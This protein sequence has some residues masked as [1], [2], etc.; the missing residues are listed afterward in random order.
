MS[1]RNTTEKACF[2]VNPRSAGGR[3]GSKLDEVRRAAERWFEHSEIRCTE[4]PRHATELAAAAVE[5]GFDLVVAVGGDGTA[6]EVVNGLF[7]GETARNPDVVFTVIPAGTGSDLVKTLAMP[8]Y[9]EDA[10]ATAAIGSTRRSDAVLAHY[11]AHDGTSDA[12]EICINVAGFGMS[13]DVVQRV[14]RSK[15]RFGGT[16]SFITGTVASLVAYEPPQVDIRW[17]AADGSKGEWGGTIFNVFIANGAYCGS[18]MWVGRG[19][20]MQDGALD[21]TIIPDLSLPRTIMGSP[22]LFTGTM[23]RVKGVVRCAIREVEA[24]LR[25]AEGAGE[26]LLDLDGEQPGRLP[27]SLRILPE[28]LCIRGRWA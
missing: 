21:M 5:E 18:G 10:V 22:R 17:T 2:I 4:R 9:I 8:P 6:H 23:D 27:V 28:T 20:S 25:T 13:G 3:T 1:E 15:K 12:S 24:T 11:T 7:D 19:G 26:V 14:N 16:V